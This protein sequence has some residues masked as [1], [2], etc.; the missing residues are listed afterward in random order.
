MKINRLVPVV[1][2]NNLTESKEFYIKYFGFQILFDSDWYVQMAS[3]NGNLQI[4][5]IVPNHKS[6]PPVFQSGFD[7][8]GVF[9]TLEVDDVDSELQRIKKEGLEVSLDIRDEPW[10]ERHFAVK[11]PNKIIIN[12]SQSIPP[13]GEF[14]Q[15]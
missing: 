8:K 11:D 4:A 13:T 3:H 6:Q 1:S 2:T 14:A 9:Y 5:F 7:G 12:V 10:G 15:D